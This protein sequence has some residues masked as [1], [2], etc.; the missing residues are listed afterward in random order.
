[1]CLISL[2]TRGALDTWSRGRSTAALGGNVWVIALSVA[3]VVVANCGASAYIARA[4]VY[5]VR[6]KV[7]QIAI[8][9]FVPIVGAAFCSY[10]LYSDRRAI[11]HRRP[12]SS[13]SSITESDAIQYG[14]DHHGGR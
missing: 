1:M 4:P 6:Q 14:R 10:F 11:A 7:T 5:G 13:D 3:V 12:E 9:W 8:I 2:C